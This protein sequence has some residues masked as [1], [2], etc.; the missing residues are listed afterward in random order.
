MV[1]KTVKNRG[2]LYK[3]HRSIVKSLG[4]RSPETEQVYAEFQKGKS[5][6]AERL[7]SLASQID[8]QASILRTLGAGRLPVTAARALRAIQDH[9]AD[10]SV[11]GTNALYAYERL[12]GVRVNAESTATADID[13]LVDD[14]HQL[15]LYTEERKPEALE[16]IIRKNV[17]AS[18][19]MRSAGDYRMTNDRGYMIEFVRPEARPPYRVTPGSVPDIQ[20]DV[21]PASIFG[22]QW[23]LNAPQVTAMVIDDRGF[24]VD[25]KCPDPRHWAVHKLWLAEREDREPIKKIRDRQQ[26]DLV[27]RLITE[28]LPY[29]PLDDDFRR[30]LPG[31]LAK[32]LP[33]IEAGSETRP[34][35]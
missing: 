6:I 30:S 15:K 24:P 25:M 28:R 31:S 16:Q 18:F 32:H 5:E 13:F 7:K 27:I 22:L 1:P 3:R 10:L 21:T 26:A 14:R 23:L 12:A 19:R 34:G 35:W 17:D 2:A 11:V 29:L 20:D 9:G 33:D 4:P 8:I